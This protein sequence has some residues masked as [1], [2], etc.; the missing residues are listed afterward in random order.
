MAAASL[1]AHAKHGSRDGS[2]QTDG[3]PDSAAACLGLD[4]DSLLGYNGGQR[5]ASLGKSPFPGPL[6]HTG[7]WTRWGVSWSMG[8]FIP[9][10]LGSLHATGS[11]TRCWTGWLCGPL[12]VDVR[13]G[14][15]HG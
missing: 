14:R 9:R 1:P 6:C 5:T 7:L 12:H 13:A 15:M 10:P 3:P 11:C 4:P 2:T 8:P